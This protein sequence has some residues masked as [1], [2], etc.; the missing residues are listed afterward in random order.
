M[1]DRAEILFLRRLEPHHARL[2]PRHPE[3]PAVHARRARQDRRARLAGHRRSRRLAVQ[4]GGPHLGAAQP[5]LLRRDAAARRRLLRRPVH[6]GRWSPIP[7]RM[8]LSQQGRG[9][10][11]SRDHRARLEIPAHGARRRASARRLGARAKRAKRRAAAS[12]RSRPATRSSTNSA[13]SRAPPCPR[14]SRTRWS[15][16]CSGWKTSPNAKDL[17]RLL[18]TNGN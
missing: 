5:A 16:P 15:R 3:A 1:G 2:D 7:K 18:R 4:A 8:E 11:R 12:S 14:A 17:I 9:R 10:R 6:R 13:S